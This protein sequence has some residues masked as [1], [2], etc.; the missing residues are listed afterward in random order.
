MSWIN[1]FRSGARG[2]AG[3]KL[4]SLLT[5]LGI[6]FGIAAVICTVGIGQATADSVNARI[7][8]LGSNLLTV[9]PGSTT[10]S[11][12]SGGAGSA[13]TLTMADAFALATHADAPDVAAVAP[14]AQRS[15]TLVDGSANWTASVQG[16]TSGWL[17]TDARTL[18]SGEFF[19]DADVSRHDHVIVIGSTTA[20][21]L[22]ASIGNT[23]VV[24]R[25]PFTL[26]GILAS[27]GSQGFGNADDLGVIPITTAQDMLVGSGTVQRILL[28][29]ADANDVGTAY[30]EADQLL[31]QTHHV[32][33][34]TPDFTITTQSQVLTTAQSVTS[35][36]TVL[37]ASI[38]AI[39]LLVGGIGVMNI[40]LVSVTERTAEIGLRKALGATPRDVR[41]QFLVEAA[42]LSLIGGVLGVG[43]GLLV[44]LVLPRV[45]TIAVTVTVAPVLVAV[46]VSAIVGLVFGIV[47]AARAARLA[48]IDAL[49][50]Q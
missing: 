49:R 45:S 36:L 39:S 15:T 31:I 11:G 38:A 29:A 23:I 21:A 16:S 8:S 12:V 1:I 19:T 35:T 33:A 20:A 32:T 50:G 13:A 9:S 34:S 14:V 22:G 30:A 18:S 24:N 4:R 46:I 47:P 40:M 44:A 5:V 48:P 7:A 2:L 6:L 43:A 26:I 3:H 17:I 28:S 41:R 10:T 42:A 25:V 27:N 37:L